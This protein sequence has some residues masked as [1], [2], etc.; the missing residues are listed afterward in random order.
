MMISLNKQRKIRSF[1]IQ[2]QQDFNQL[3]V[4][5]KLKVTCQLGQSDSTEMPISIRVLTL[6][7]QTRTTEPLLLDLSDG[8]AHSVSLLKVAGCKY[9]WVMDR[10]TRAKLS[11]L[12][13]HQ[14]L[15]LIPRNW[16]PRLNQIQHRKFLTQRQ[17]H[18]TIRIKMMNDLCPEE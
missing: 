11:T 7:T 14:C 13:N 9:I 5:L 15:W 8:Q 17:E 3:Q 18:K 2:L 16:L 12:L 1:P 4:M 10:S 6:C